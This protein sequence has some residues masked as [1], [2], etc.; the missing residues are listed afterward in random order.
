MLETVGV[1]RRELACHA[2]SRN[3]KKKTTTKRNVYI[4]RRI[5]DNKSHPLAIDTDVV[6]APSIV[7][8]RR[9]SLVMPPALY[10]RRTRL[11][12]PSALLLIIVRVICVRAIG[13]S[14]NGNRKWKMETENG[15]RQNL[16]QTNTRIKPLINDHLLK[17]TSI[18]R[19]PLYK[20]HTAIRWLRVYLI[21]TF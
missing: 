17:T 3:Y 5:G 2:T 19:P 11:V 21:T 4:H 13:N 9:T 6:Y 8:N 20:D 18:Q 10:F 1:S 15:N 7:L 14:G 12:M 16:M